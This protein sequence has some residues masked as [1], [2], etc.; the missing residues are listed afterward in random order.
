MKRLCAW[1]LA[2]VL[3]LS[4]TALASVTPEADKTALRAGETVN[5]TVKLDAPIEGV[6]GLS[7]RLYFNDELFDYVPA[8]CKR[9]DAIPAEDTNLKVSAKAKTD[10]EG[11][12]YAQ[13]SYVDLS[14]AGKTVAAG[15]LYTIAFVAKADISA[16]SQATFELKKDKIRD[17]SRNEITGDAV[18]VPADKASLSVDVQPAAPEVTAI[19]LDKTELTLTVGGE[20]TLIATVTA[21]EGAETTV[22]WTSENEAVAAVADGKVTAAG[23]GRTV[24]TATAGDKTAACMVTVKRSAD[25]GYTVELSNMPSDTMQVKETMS[26]TVKVGVGENDTRT[27]YNAADVVLKYDSKLLSYA[28]A[29]EAEGARISDDKNGTLKI[30]RYGENL[31]LGD[32]VTLSFTGVATGEAKVSFESAKI[33]ESANAPIQDAPD[34]VCINDSVTITIGGYNVTLPE[35]G[36]FKGDP[37]VKPGDDYTFEATDRDHYD[38]SDVKAKI[39]D[40]YVDVIDNGDGTYT[41]KASD[42]TGDV[43]IEGTRTGKF[44]TVTITG[45]DTTGADKAQYGVDYTFTID[46]KDG[47]SYTLN[48]NLPYTDNGDGTYTIAGA[49]ITEN[50]TINVTK[51][52]DVTPPAGTTAITIT[53]VTDA[54]VEGGLNQ[55]A[56]NGKDFTLKLVKD[57]AYDYVVKVGETEIKPNEDGSYTIPGSMIN[58]TALTVTVEKTVAVPTVEVVE[59]LKLKQAEGEPSGQSMWLVLVSGKPVDGNVYSFDG[60]A[61][62]TSEKYDGA[63]CY[64]M[65]SGK[66]IEEVREAAAVLV[67]QKA[68][69]AEAVAYEG[70]VNK[71]AAVDINDAQLVYD[72]YKAEKYQDFT[73]VTAESFLRADM[74]GSK[75][76]TVKDAAEI[77]AKVHTEFPVE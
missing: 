37:A 19:E 34:A 49:A 51:T 68:G 66:T 41:I 72:M 62:F 6:Y 22:T 76:I 44:Y 25:E 11:K 53:G 61:M 4:A 38:Y 29:T 12:K 58:G 71:T 74:D 15:T 36:I 14:A 24:I 7:Y 2:L 42:I 52:K 48:V 39:G 65:I 27:T 69:T 43:T 30:V 47:Y 73:T 56:T 50:I 75:S 32:L 17:T 67:D 26:V 5:V 10:A 20:E 13:I 16:D 8:S 60:N 40:N 18:D 21:A 63:Y 28:G 45:E 59:Y 31:A 35:G 54:E 1:I 23:V 57:A 77:V 3:L 70:D 33:D 64:L 46:K 9:G 55:T